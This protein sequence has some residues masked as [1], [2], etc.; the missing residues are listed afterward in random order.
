MR[1]DYTSVGAVCWPYYLKS[2]RS[3]PT[4]FFLETIQLCPALAE[5]LRNARLIAPATATGNYSYQ[6]ERMAGE[7]YLL[8]GDAFAFVDPVFSSGVM[9]AM[10]GATRAADVVDAW[11]LDPDGAAPQV[12]RFERDVR[13]GL[14][15]FSWFIY[16]M[17]SPAMRNLF[18]NPR[19]KLRMQ[20]ALLSLLAGDLY[21]GTPIYWSL[22]A[23]KVV[24]YLA[25]LRMRAATSRHGGGA[26]VRS[27]IAQKAPP[28]RVPEAREPLAGG[29]WP[30]PQPAACAG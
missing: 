7:G 17:T 2:R 11:L 13:H 9:L 15:E 26:S 5:R 6:C 16:R 25:S 22:R 8:I 3:D 18:M 24:Y 19:N 27:P 4:A 1:N 28:L 20:E 30:P 21:R 10:Q 12:R 29:C 14:R 23:F